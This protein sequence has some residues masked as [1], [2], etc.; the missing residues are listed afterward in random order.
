MT[1][2]N[3]SNSPLFTIGYS[4]LSLASFISILKKH[5]IGAIADVRSSPFSKYNPEFNFNGL[6]NALKKHEIAYVFLGEELGARRTE[7]ECYKN[8]KVSYTLVSETLLFKQGIKRLLTGVEKMRVSLMCAE[9]D[10]INCHRFVLICHHL[11]R[12]LN[13]IKHILD[14]GEVENNV[15]SEERLLSIY[16]LNN[17]ELFRPKNEI[18]QEAYE[19]QAEKIAYV[20]KQDHNIER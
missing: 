7:A 19:K 11:R 14:N 1:S 2:N 8:G 20:N 3:M 6:E 4:N 5:R 17:M 13:E 12:Q 10:P 15:Q 9:K 16:R 18:L